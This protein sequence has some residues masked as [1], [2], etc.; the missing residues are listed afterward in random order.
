MNAPA[1]RVPAPG[2][3]A[4]VWRSVTEEGIFVIA[5]CQ[6]PLPVG[7]SGSKQVTAKPFVSGG[8]PDHFSCGEMSSPP[9]PKMP[10]RCLDASASPPAMSS[11]ASAKLAAGMRPQQIGDAYTAPDG[12]AYTLRD[13]TQLDLP[14][15]QD[16]LVTMTP[17]TSAPIYEEVLRFED[18][19]SGPSSGDG[20][21]GL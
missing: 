11:L 14:A 4:L 10:E 13:E 21:K 9:A 20:P 18:L 6:K 17:T 3:P 7:A 1:G 12:V 19:P 8:K 16:R 15:R 5:R 2:S